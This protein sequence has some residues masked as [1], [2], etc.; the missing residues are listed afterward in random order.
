MI[1][2]NLN[3]D[4]SNKNSIDYHIIIDKL[5]DIPNKI[6]LYGEYEKDLFIDG[7]DLKNVNRT[8]EISMD[9]EVI[10]EVILSNITDTNIYI[11]YINIDNSIISDITFYYLVDED[12]N[13]ILKL[14][15][16]LNIDDQ[17]EDENYVSNKDTPLSYLSLSES[18]FILNSLDIK[19]DI[20][21]NLKYNKETVK[22]YK[23]KLKYLGGESGIEIFYGPRGTGKTNLAFQMFKDLGRSVIFIPNNLIEVSLGNPEFINFIKNIH[24]PALIIDDC[25]FLTNSQF[26]KMNLFS[27]NLLQL[28]ESPILGNLNLLIVLIFN[29]DLD[30]IDDNLLSSNS[31]INI[32]EFDELNI[33]EVIKLKEYLNISVE[34]SNKSKLSHI[35]NPKKIKQTGK[36]GL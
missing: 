27:S 15:K 20:P 36:I 33:K 1:K 10:N 16:D 22:E 6:Y 7:V 13:F 4:I 35:L 9:G 14:V 25:E 24:N 19:S 18:G 30:H 17:L 31:L 23:K 21:T 2:K 29:E 11:T 3:F 28:V 8:S 32:L 12:Y 26:S 34:E 5:G